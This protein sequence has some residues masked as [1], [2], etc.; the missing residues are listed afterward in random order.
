MRWH[1]GDSGPA[2]RRAQA[3]IKRFVN[4]DAFDTIDGL[5]DGVR[6]E[7]VAAAGSP[8]TTREALTQVFAKARACVVG[9]ME[10]ETYPG[11]VVSEQYEDMM[12]GNGR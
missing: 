12:A 3:I 7:V 6:R 9:L 10:A 1:R 5:D 11:F 4:L 2:Y 8:S